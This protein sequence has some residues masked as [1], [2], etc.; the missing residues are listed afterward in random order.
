M[1]FSRVL[2]LPVNNF[3]NKQEDTV[4]NYALM[5]HTVG[6]SFPFQS[7]ISPL[8]MCEPHLQVLAG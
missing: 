1:M 8:I 7:T 2:M 4:N 6:R 5:S 3:K